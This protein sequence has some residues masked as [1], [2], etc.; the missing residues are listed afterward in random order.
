MGSRSTTLV[1]LATV[2]TVGIGLAFADTPD[3]P[4]LNITLVKSDE[5]ELTWTSST[6]ENGGHSFDVF[7]CEGSLS[8]TPTLEIASNVNSPFSDQT[9]EGE[10]DYC[11]LI[12]E[13]HGQN[14]VNSNIECATTPIFQAEPD[15]TIFAE[16]IGKNSILVTWLLPLA[17]K[18]NGFVFN[19]DIEKSDDGGQNYILIGQQTRQ[20]TRVPLDHD[21]DYREVYNFLDEDLNE[22][23]IKIYRVSAKTGGGQGQGE[24]NIKYQSETLPIE[25]PSTL[26]GYLIKADGYG[27]ETTTS[28]NPQPPLMLGWIAWFFPNAF[29]GGNPIFTSMLDPQNEVF[30]IDIEPIP[31]PSY[32][33][34][35]CEQFLDVS[36]KR[37]A[38][39]GQEIQYTVTILENGTAKHQFA[40]KITDRAKRVFNNQYFIPFEDQV[41]TMFDL[42]SVQIDV[43]SEV[44]D[45]RAFELHGVDFYVPEDNGAC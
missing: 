25:I 5:I 23:D 32:T 40:D 21:N 17:E 10:R 19:Y 15:M 34:Q 42:L 12:E 35:I 7:R 41:I 36:F 28:G 26:S 13:S 6:G 2:C 20:F 44:G 45:P 1:L 27:I 16:K 4:I 9:V 43:D 39:L 30:E 38:D 33:Q 24:G 22:G 18:G 37:S 11:Y 14:A 3:T 8:C 29:A 31:I